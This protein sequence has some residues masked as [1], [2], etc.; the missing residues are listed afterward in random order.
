MNIIIDQGNTATKVALF[1]DGVQKLRLKYADF[2]AEDFLKLKENHTFKGGIFSSV[3]KHIDTHLITCLRETIP[4]FL[5]FDHTLK[6]PIDIAYKTPNTL[7][8]DRLAAVVG[9]T[10]KCPDKNILII[11]AGTAITY[12]LVEASG[13]YVGGNISPGMNTRFKALH[14]YT[15]MLPLLKEENN[16]PLIGT[17]T[18]SAIQAGVV[19]GIIYEMDGYIDALR[20]EY[21]DL[22]VFLTGGHSIYF[23][24]KLKNSIFA[25]TNLVMM[26]LNRLIDYN[27]KI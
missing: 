5:I 18:D 2:T 24:T 8:M 4:S 22:L 27:A 16:V 9:A 21:P 13:L 26:G 7:G 6:L 19:N 17:S 20:N 14:D 10:H 25:D 23:E 11:D 1:E 15:D 3:K 12:E